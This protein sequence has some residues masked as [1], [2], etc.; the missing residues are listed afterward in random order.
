LTQPIYV[1][2]SGGDDAPAINAAFAAN[3][4]VELGAENYKIASPIMVPQNGCLRGQCR[5]TNITKIANTDMLDLA[6]GASISD[7][8]LNGDGA[9]FTGRGVVVRADQHY[10]RM[11]NVHVTSNGYCV[12]LEA[13]DAG[14]HMKIEDCFITRYPDLQAYSIKLPDGDS[15]AGG[16]RTLRDIRAGG[17]YGVDI[18]GAHNTMIDRCNMALIRMNKECKT[19]LVQNSRLIGPIEWRGSLLWVSFNNI[20][21]G[22]YITPEC[23]QSVFIAPMHSAPIG[24]QD[25]PANGNVVW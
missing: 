15:L 12:H 24:R 17:G 21:N 16:N 1:P 2:A 6:Y 25:P 8:S 10:Q 18:S 19:V 7:F 23:L 22:C 14:G 9:N 4:S 13:F 11:V 3:K 20:S 5:A